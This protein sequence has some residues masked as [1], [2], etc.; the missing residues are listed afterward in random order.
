MTQIHVTIDGAAAA[1]RKTGVLTA[2]M[3]GATATFDFSPVWEGLQITAVF[4]A[5]GVARDVA[6]TDGSVTIPHEVLAQPGYILRVGAE[7]RKPDG[8]LVIPTVWARVGSICQGANPT[9]DPALAP[10]PS[11]YDRL[12][13]QIEEMKQQGLDTGAVEAMIAAYLQAHPPK[14][15]SVIHFVNTAIKTVDDPVSNPGS[16]TTPPK[17]GDVAITTDY[18][19]YEILAVDEETGSVTAERKG[20][21]KGAPG[22]SPVKGT[23]YWTDADKAE[24]KAYVDEAILGGAW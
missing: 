10:T 9:G 15:G 5:G 18:D 24:I 13:A 1:V 17:A 7:G 12:L 16:Y 2:G 11:Q 20:N 6:V 4:E 3:V 21:I 8:T 14:D 23:D 22:Y 19:L